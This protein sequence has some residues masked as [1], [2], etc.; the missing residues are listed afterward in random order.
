MAIEKWEYLTEFVSADIQNEGVKSFLQKKWPNWKNP[1]QFTAETM[2]PRLNGWGEQ[3]WEL[4]NMEPV[5]IGNNADVNF[6]RTGN[7]YSNVYFCVFK[8]RKSE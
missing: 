7:F 5:L 4:V 1:P 2:I 3:G 6:A 8:R